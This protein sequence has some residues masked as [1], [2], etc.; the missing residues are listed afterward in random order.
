[1]QALSKQAV[2]NTIYLLHHPTWLA[3]L[4]SLV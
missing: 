4:I 3:C 1:M 2:F